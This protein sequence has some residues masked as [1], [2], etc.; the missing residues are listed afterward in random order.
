MLN[1]YSHAVMHRTHFL[2]Q[3]ALSIRIHKQTDAD[4]HGLQFLFNTRCPLQASPFTLT[5][6]RSASKQLLGHASTSFQM[7]Q[8]PG[9]ISD[10]HVTVRALVPVEGGAMYASCLALPITSTLKVT[11]QGSSACRRGSDGCLLPCTS[12]YLY[13]PFCSSRITRCMWLARCAVQH[14]N[15]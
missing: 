8:Q 1:S 7:S 11:L 9:Q 5:T 4:R 2:K 12:D 6:I 15:V 3:I 13:T 10:D 14:V